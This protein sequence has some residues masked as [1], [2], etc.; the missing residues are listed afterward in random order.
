MNGQIGKIWFI[1]IKTKYPLHFH[2]IFKNVDAR[3][4]LA[5]LA[6]VADR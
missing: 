5:F 3:K 1:N 2:K 6:F 4:T